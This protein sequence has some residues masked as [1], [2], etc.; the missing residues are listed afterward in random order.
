MIPEIIRR[1]NIIGRTIA[2]TFVPEEDVLEMLL[3]EVV[4]DGWDNVDT[5]FEVELVIEGEV[6]EVEEEL[7]EEEGEVEGEVEE[8][9]EVADKSLD[10]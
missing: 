3:V 1:R 5:V 4:V 8:E 9:V 2:R 6:E 10:S 7:E